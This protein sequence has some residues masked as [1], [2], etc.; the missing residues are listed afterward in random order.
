M[1]WR[2]SKDVLSPRVDIKPRPAT[3]RGL[4]AIIAQIFDP[5]GLCAPFLLTGR[6]L[7]PEIL[8]E[9]TGWDDPIPVEYKKQWENWIKVLS[10]LENLEVLRCYWNVDVKKYELH[11]FANSSKY[12]MSCVSYL[13]MVKGSEIKVAFVMGKSKVISKGNTLSISRLELVAA[14]LDARMHRHIKDSL[15]LPLEKCYR[16]SDSTVVLDWLSN[17]KHRYKKFV[18]Q[19]ISEIHQLVG[20]DCWLHIASSE[21]IADICSRGINPKKT[22]AKCDYLCGPKILYQVVP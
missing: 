19:R 11:T 12:G 10:N 20:K 5:I 9:V 1:Q 8:N 22:S 18:T 2:L 17:T 15:N 14:V 7:L 3:K 4:W 21:I 16:Y 6:R 13:R